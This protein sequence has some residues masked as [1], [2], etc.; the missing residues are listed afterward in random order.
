MKV[1][2]LVA[3]LAEILGE[4]GGAKATD[5]IVISITDFTVETVD[6]VELVPDGSDG[7]AVQLTLSFGYED[8]DNK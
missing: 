7:T 8:Q 5:T 2:E 1:Y 6:A 3:K 4:D